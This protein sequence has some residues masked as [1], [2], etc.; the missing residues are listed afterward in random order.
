MYSGIENQIKNNLE[1]DAGEIAYNNL[2]LENEK[3]RNDHR[4]KYQF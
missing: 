1:K 3:A 2:D 4:A